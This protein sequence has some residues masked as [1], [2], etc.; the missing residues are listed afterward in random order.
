MLVNTQHSWREGYNIT[1]LLEMHVNDPFGT[2]T[3]QVKHR[4]LNKKIYMTLLSHPV[5]VLDQGKCGKA[6]WHPLPQ[7]CQTLLITASVA[8][9][10]KDFQFKWLKSLMSPQAT[11]FFSHV[12][13]SCSFNNCYQDTLIYCKKLSSNRNDSLNWTPIYSAPVFLLMKV[14]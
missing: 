6:I 5:V 1:P 9:Q 7:T 12:L 2:N 3:P 14:L 11:C 4:L 10:N 13:P 8:C